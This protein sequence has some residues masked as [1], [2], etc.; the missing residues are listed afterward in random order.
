MIRMAAGRV[1]KLRSGP[2]RAGIDMPAGMACSARPGRV[3]RDQPAGLAGQHP[4]Q[5]GPA[6]RQD[7]PVEPGLLPNPGTRLV[8]RAPGAPRHSPHMQVFDADGVCRICNAPGDLMAPVAPH[9]RHAPTGLRKA[10]ARA[11]PTARAAPLAR[12]LPGKTLGP[13]L[14]AARIRS[15]EQ[16]AIARRDLPGVHVDAKRDPVVRRPPGPVP[17]GLPGPGNRQWHTTCRR[18]ASARPRPGGLA[19]AGC[20]HAD[21]SSAT[22]DRAGADGRGGQPRA[23]RRRRQ[24]RIRRP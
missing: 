1:S 15:V 7:D 18:R 23:S 24:R 6:C 8:D 3:H 14:Q 11:L 22:Q 17:G 4:P 20:L 5:L 10:L 16:P 13:G 12:Q 21:G 2:P 9:A 19:H